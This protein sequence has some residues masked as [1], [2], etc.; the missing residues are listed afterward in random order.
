M[1]RFP[2]SLALMLT[3]ATP[4]AAQEVLG[5]LE[6][7]QND[8]FRTW[9]VTRDGAQTQSSWR[10][11]APGVINLSLWGHATDT[12]ATSVNDALILDFN[13]MTAA[14][15]PL[16]VDPTLQYL[17]EGYGGGWLALDDSS[18]SVTVE[19]LDVTDASLSIAGTFTAQLTYSTDIM[20]QILETSKTQTMEGRFSAVLPAN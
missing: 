18:I 8:T 12:S 11:M 5:T 15:T 20:R 14:G 7:R 17:A 16:V 2:L 6:A 3:V 10:Q 4:I 13:V 9:F 19:K 1:T